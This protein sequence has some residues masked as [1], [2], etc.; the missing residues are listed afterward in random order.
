MRL[1]TSVCCLCLLLTASALAQS[2]SAVILGSV[3]DSQERAVADT[4]MTVR[5]VD[6]GFTRATTTDAAGRYRLTAI[7]PGRYTLTAAKAGF[8]TVVREGLI[9][10]LGADAV[11]DVELPIA[12]VTER[13]IVTADVPV[14]E[15]T[16][17]AIGN[18]HLRPP[19]PSS[20]YDAVWRTQ[21]AIGP[22]N[23]GRSARGTR[24]GCL[25]AR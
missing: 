16:T 15:T 25:S 9:L 1:T 13:L 23:P 3:R 22:P 8:R 20:R 12:G 2:D 10:L 21:Q 5:N 14:V 24:V 4:A 7:P 6:T 18:F 19:E 17:S 11:I